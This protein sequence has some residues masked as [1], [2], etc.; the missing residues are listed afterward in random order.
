MSASKL[1][2]KC[3]NFY[4]FQASSPDFKEIFSLQE[5]L[6]TFLLSSEGQDPFLSPRA[7]PRVQKIERY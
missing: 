7:A 6:S 3:H 1:A 4:T 5:I 2:L